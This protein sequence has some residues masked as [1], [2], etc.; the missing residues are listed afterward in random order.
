MGLTRQD[1]TFGRGVSA[2]PEEVFLSM[3]DGL[4]APNSAARE[5]TS[6]KSLGFPC[7]AGQLSAC[8]DNQPGLGGWRVDK[9]DIKNGGGQGAGAVKR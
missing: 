2:Y 6:I 9:K 4:L 5:V 1:T 8:K 7:I 3:R